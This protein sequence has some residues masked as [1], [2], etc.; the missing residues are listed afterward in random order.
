[1]TKTLFQQQAII[2]NKRVFDANKADC[3]QQQE[4][5]GKANGHLPVFNDH[6][7]ELAPLELDKTCLA[8]FPT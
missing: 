5:D 1:L 3:G 2:K 6:F 8:D 7:L 4:Y